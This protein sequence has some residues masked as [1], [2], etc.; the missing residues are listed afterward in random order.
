MRTFDTE[1]GYDRRA[2]LWYYMR[3]HRVN[4]VRLLYLHRQIFLR[5]Q[6]V[7]YRENSLPPLQRPITQM[8]TE[9]MFMESVCFLWNLN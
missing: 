2:T 5:P 8:Y 1:R 4:R 9:Q 3:Y 6:L 7:T